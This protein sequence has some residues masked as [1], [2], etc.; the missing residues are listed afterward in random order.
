MQGPGE[1]NTPFMSSSA[2]RPWDVYKHAF[3][4][5]HRGHPLWDPSPI[6]SYHQVRLGDVG[7]I[8]K[9]RFHL[10]FSAG[11]ELG[12]RVLG[13][14]VPPKFIP[15]KLEGIVQRYRPPG[16]LRTA[17]VRQVGVELKVKAELTVPWSLWSPTQ[18]CLLNSPP[19]QVLF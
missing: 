19:R 13:V 3:A 5:Y 15:L 9:G 8:R 17:S 11:D 12:S 16:Y 10:L 6:Y 7:Y 4:P 14:D 18:S 1:N 2:P